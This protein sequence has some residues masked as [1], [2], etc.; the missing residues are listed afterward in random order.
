MSDI[1]NILL[2]WELHQRKVMI[3][4]IANHCDKHRSTISRWINGINEIGL[5]EYLYIYRIAKEK[6]RPGRQI[7]SRVKN[8]I[9]SIYLEDPISGYKLQKILKKKYNI[10]VSVSKIYLIMKVVA[11]EK[12]IN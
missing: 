11:N 12:H 4:D 5:R 3:N 7:N 8:L 2:A 10:K 6:K 1:K 9:R